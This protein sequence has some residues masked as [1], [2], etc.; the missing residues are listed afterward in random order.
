M[1]LKNL[2]NHFG[3]AV[4]DQIICLNVG[5]ENDET[6]TSD[7]EESFYSFDIQSDELSDNEIINGSYDENI[8][9]TNLHDVVDKQGIVSKAND[10]E[11]MST[12]GACKWQL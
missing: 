11:N 10:N 7:S 9:N 4:P 1:L 12:S 5:V 3:Y 2:N 8:N 6:F